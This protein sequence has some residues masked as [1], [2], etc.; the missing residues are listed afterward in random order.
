MECLLKFIGPGEPLEVSYEIPEERY[1]KTFKEDLPHKTLE[2]L[3]KFQE[4][5]EEFYKFAE[6]LYQNQNLF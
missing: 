4:L 6:E 3:R 1:K 2:R 5:D